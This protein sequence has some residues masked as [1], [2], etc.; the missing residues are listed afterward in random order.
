MNFLVFSFDWCPKNGDE[1]IQPIFHLVKQVL[2]IIHIV[3]PIILVIMTSLD[4]IKK[5]IN[6][7]DKEGQKKIMYRAIGALVVFLAPTFVDL[8]LRVIDWGNGGNSGMADPSPSLSK[9]WE[10]A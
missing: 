6:P 9:C 7:D 1:S 3:V 10:D 4:V 8:T 5:V 2:N